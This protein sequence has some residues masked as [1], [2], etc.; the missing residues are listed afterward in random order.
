MKQDSITLASVHDYNNLYGL[1][2][3]HPLVSVIDLKQASK[4]I[5]N[6][7]ITYGLYAIFLKNG[8][9]CTIKYGRREYDYQEGTIVCFAPGQVVGVEVK[10]PELAPDVVGLLFHPDIIFDTPLG[11]NIDKYT[12]FDYSQMEALHL[13]MDERQLFL[14][15]LDKI[16]QETMHPVDRHSGALISSNIQLLLDYLYRFYDRQFITRHKVNSAVVEEF[17]LHLKE[18]FATSAASHGLPSVSYF[19]DKAN[20]S[21]GYFGD[22]IKKETGINAKDYISNHIISLARHRLLTTHDDISE[23][24]YALGFQYPQ[25]FTRQF[26]RVTGLT[27]KQYRDSIN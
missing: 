3:H 20:L 15:C 5:N 19:A 22:L 4:T 14:D 1:E 8:S 6:L 16:K 21:A 18:Y 25:H 7:V 23:I 12:F 9:Q 24:A 2:T 26:K 27:P 11:A 17:E 10:N 13:S